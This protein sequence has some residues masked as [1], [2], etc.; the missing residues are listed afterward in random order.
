MVRPRHPPHHPSPAGA[1]LARD[2]LRS[3]LTPRPAP[4]RP[5][6]GL[7]RESRPDL[8][9]YPGLRPPAALA[10]HRF[11][12]VTTIRRRHR[13]PTCPL[14]PPHRYSGLRRLSLAQYGQ[15]LA[16]TLEDN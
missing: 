13:N 11:L 15:S 4:A 14:R 6:G 5:P 2:P 8:L 9:G 12:D 10:G 7:V 3:G 1:L 16:K